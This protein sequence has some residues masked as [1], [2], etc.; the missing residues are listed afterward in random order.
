MFDGLKLFF[1]GGSGAAEWRG[2]EAGDFQG[3]GQF[4]HHATAAFVTRE[5]EVR[6]LVFGDP[7]SFPAV[8]PPGAEAAPSDVEDTHRRDER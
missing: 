2:R 4:H 1:F 7:E 3:A 8:D 5:V 6:G